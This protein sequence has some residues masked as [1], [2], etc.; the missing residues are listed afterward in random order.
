MLKKKVTHDGFLEKWKKTSD[1]CLL[2]G[3]SQEKCYVKSSKKWQKDK[4]YVMPSCRIVSIEMLVES[5]KAWSIPGWKVWLILFLST[6]T[7]QLNFPILSQSSDN[8]Q[9]S[10]CNVVGYSKYTSH[11]LEIKVS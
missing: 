10:S 9:E 5:L 7:F 1:K 2:R 6:I 4:V 8:W 11:H 3:M